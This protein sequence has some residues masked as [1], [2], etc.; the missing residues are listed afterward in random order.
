MAGVGVL[1]ASDRTQTAQRFVDYLLS[2]A[3]QQY[4]AASQEDDGFE[5]P[6]IE[7][8]TANVALPRLESLQTPDLDLNDLTD[9]EGTL[10]L[11]RKAGALP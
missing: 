11:L 3:A 4:F 2:P 7:G 1:A 5:Y 9:L 10:D 8:V 6:L